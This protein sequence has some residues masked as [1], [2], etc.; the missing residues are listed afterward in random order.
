MNSTSFYAADARNL[1]ICADRKVID[2]LNFANE[3]SL[4]SLLH[5][6]V[7][8][9]IEINDFIRCCSNKTA[10]TCTLRS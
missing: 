4:P 7:D 9:S 10:L 3:H 8:E 1:A 6:I 2:A 5:F